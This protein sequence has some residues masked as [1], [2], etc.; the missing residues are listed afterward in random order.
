[1]TA[2]APVGG[3]ALHFELDALRARAARVIDEH[4]SCRGICRA[5]GWTFPCP[6]ACLAEHNLQMCS[7]QPPGAED[8]TINRPSCDGSRLS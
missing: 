1:M 3:H 7:D 2:Q 8:P 5:C 6:R 4:V